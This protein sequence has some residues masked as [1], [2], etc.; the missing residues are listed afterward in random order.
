MALIIPTELADKYGLLQILLFDSIPYEEFEK[1]KAAYKAH[2]KKIGGLML[3]QEPTLVYFDRADI[4]TVLE[5]D[6]TFLTFMFACTDSPKHDGLRVMMCG[7]NEPGHPVSDH[8]IFEGYEKGY[9]S[10]QIDRYTFEV[11]RYLFEKRLSF[12]NDLTNWRGVQNNIKEKAP[13]LDPL[14]KIIK[15][16]GDI[17]RIGVYL[18]VVDGHYNIM[19]ILSKDD[20]KDMIPTS[21]SR[22]TDNQAYDN[23]TQCCPQ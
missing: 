11:G 2:N 5:D 18:A 19:I 21:D 13:D 1:R 8:K 15:D 16:N 23:S 9:Q 4:L 6:P 7:M 20:F 17:N 22:Q 3:S 12:F 14:I 10:T